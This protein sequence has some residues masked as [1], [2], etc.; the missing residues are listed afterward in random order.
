MA[1][2]GE[3]RILDVRE[4]WEFDAARIESSILM[5]MSEIPA[6]IAELDPAAPL[7][8]VCHLGVRSMHVVA[9]LRQQGFTRAQSVRGG[10]DAWSI[11]VD[12]SIP[13]Y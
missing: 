5:P 7:L 12:S 8:V 10:I 11:E 13:R 4:P 3:T 6:R 1:S 9:W 2:R